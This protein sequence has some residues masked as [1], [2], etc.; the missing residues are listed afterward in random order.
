M[1]L[2]LRLRL[3]FPFLLGTGAVERRRGASAY[4]KDL[5]RIG[6]IRGSRG[7]QR[8]PRL[9]GHRAAVAIMHKA[10]S[11][12]GFRCTQSQRLMTPTSRQLSLDVEGH[13]AV[14]KKSERLEG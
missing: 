8:E 13:A 6:R 7:S 1:S 14:V 9:T 3:P 4:C 11:P 5:S 12:A 2:L 10:K